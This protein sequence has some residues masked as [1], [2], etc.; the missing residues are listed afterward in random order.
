V[1]A[2]SFRQLIL[3]QKAFELTEKI[4][5]FSSALP[6]SERFALIDQ[7][8]RSAISI[9]SNIAEGY[10]RNNRREY[11]QFL[12]IARGSSAELEAQLLLAEKIYQ[13]DISLEL[14][15]LTEV[16]KLLWTFDRKLRLVPRP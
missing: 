4:Y 7:I 16:Q 1:K 13:L 2:R 6:A 10:E 8:H 12:A 15:L 5:K 9:C 3:W 14:A 11:L